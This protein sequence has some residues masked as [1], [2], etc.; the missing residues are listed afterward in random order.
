MFKSSWRPSHNKN[1][2]TNTLRVSG[3]MC[4]KKHFLKNIL[5]ALKLGGFSHLLAF[6]DHYPPGGKCGIIFISCVCWNVRSTVCQQQQ[7]GIKSQG[8][9]QSRPLSPGSSACRRGNLATFRFRNQIRLS[10]LLAVTVSQ[11]S[12]VL[13]DLTRTKCLCIMSFVFSLT[14]ST[15][16]QSYLGR[17]LLPH[18]I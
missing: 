15:H 8:E 4:S 6:S 16:F 12:L 18:L 10:L 9:K 11:S 7:L 17:H 13:D 5:T 2:Y 1:T 14:D 3:F